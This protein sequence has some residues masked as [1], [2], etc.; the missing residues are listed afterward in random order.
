[1]SCL[2]RMSLEGKVSNVGGH[3]FVM[4]MREHF[5]VELFFFDDGCVGKVTDPKM[6]VVVVE[7]VAWVV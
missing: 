6:E 1:M 7:V 2:S 5:S 3:P 4:V